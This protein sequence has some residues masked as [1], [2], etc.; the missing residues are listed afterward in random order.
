V[1]TAE[2]IALL[3]ASREA[4]AEL[5]NGRPNMALQ[6]RDPLS[7]DRYDALYPGFVTSLEVDRASQLR[8][9]GITVH[10]YLYVGDTDK[11]M[12][13]IIIFFFTTF[14]VD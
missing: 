2:S 12:G 5:Q 11:M 7:L 6:K 8:A 10:P 1:T 9:L 14:G 13:F 4:A 3:R